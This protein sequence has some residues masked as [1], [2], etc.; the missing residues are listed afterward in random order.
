MMEILLELPFPPSINH[1][2]KT[3]RTKSSI[4]IY[5][6]ED[7]LRYREEVMSLVVQHKQKTGNPY[8]I[9]Y[10]KDERLSLEAHVFPFDKR[11]RDLD[12][13]MKALLDSL[14]HAYVFKNDNQ[15]DSLL[16]ERYSPQTKSCVIVKI[17]PIICVL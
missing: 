4:K 6:G 1:Y 15:I 11:K 17:K 12:N 10:F 16:I 8:Q 2:Y 9:P 7:G 5:I 3:V 14:Q 13:L